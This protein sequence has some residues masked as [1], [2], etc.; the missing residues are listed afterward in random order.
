MTVM[1]Q[2]ILQEHTDEDRHTMR[3]LGMV[4]GAFVVATAILAITVGI[5]M[6]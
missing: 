2:H 4:I 3:Q 1:T 5:L 6:G